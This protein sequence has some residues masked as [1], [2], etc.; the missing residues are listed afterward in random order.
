M[1][2]IHNAE[3]VI[4]EIVIELTPT[5]ALADVVQLPKTDTQSFY[6]RRGRSLPH[7]GRSRSADYTRAALPTPLAPEPETV[8][9][10]IK[11]FIMVN[12]PGWWPR[13]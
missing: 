8:L 2:S 9:S 3:I 12:R 7:L 1:Q 6:Q 11:E 10:R 13:P 5:E 4:E